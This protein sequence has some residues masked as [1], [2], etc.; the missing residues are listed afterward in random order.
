MTEI[1]DILDG[2][3]KDKART[4]SITTTP[5]DVVAGEITDGLE[6]RGVPQEFIA[7][8][9][10]LIVEWIVDLFRTQGFEVDTESGIDPLSPITLNER[11]SDGLDELKGDDQAIVNNWLDTPDP[12]RSYA[13][14]FVSNG[15]SRSP[16]WVVP[17]LIQT[18][19]SQE[20]SS[21]PERKRS[22]LRSLIREIGSSSTA[23]EDDGSY[24]S[25]RRN[26]EST[27]FSSPSDDNARNSSYQRQGSGSSLGPGYI[28]DSPAS[29]RSLKSSITSTPEAI[30][31]KSR[32]N[33]DIERLPS[34][35]PPASVASSAILNRC[36][37]SPSSSKLAPNNTNAIPRSTPSRNDSIRAV[38]LGI[39]IGSDQNE[40]SAMSSGRRKNSSS[41]TTRSTPSSPKLTFLSKLGSSHTATG[42]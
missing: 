17:Q 2:L 12:P 36:N 4:G 30:S 1:K 14:V 37:T 10:Q 34:S 8:N 27:S 42:T 41:S 33:S 19:S 23:H 26:R 31:P 38:G 18:N 13:G 6:H 20:S 24:D 11:L 9:G 40:R 35:S 28:T 39:G 7:E 5:S 22:S 29:P 16:D 32:A 3:V 25:S 15:R 21:Q